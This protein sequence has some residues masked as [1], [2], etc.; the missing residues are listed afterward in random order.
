MTVSGA[1]VAKAVEKLNEAQRR[2]AEFQ[3]QFALNSLGWH[4]CKAIDDRIHDALA[5]LKD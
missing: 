5:A 3:K 1:D 4:C 2:L